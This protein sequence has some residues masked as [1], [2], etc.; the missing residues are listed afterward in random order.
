MITFLLFL[1]LQ[2][3]APSY[4]EYYVFPSSDQV[5]ME[6]QLWGH[7]SKP[8]LYRVPLKTDIIKLISLAGGPLPSANLSGVKIIRKG[9]NVNVNIPDILNKGKNSFYL[10]PGDVVIVPENTSSKMK[11]VLRF[12]RESVTLAAQVVLLYTFLKAQK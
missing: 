7:V 2:A 12:L 6:V 5:L 11:D 10:E 4:P 9:E 3:P 8:G 1:Q